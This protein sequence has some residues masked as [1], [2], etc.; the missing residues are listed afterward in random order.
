MTDQRK[1]LLDE[2]LPGDDNPEL[3]IEAFGRDDLGQV[4]AER[5][6]YLDQLQRSL[7]D[8]A[9]FRKRV[10]QERARARA[11][12]TRDVLTQLLP[13][14]DDMQRALSSVP[15]D[16]S[17]KPWVEGMQLIDKKL[18][19]LLTREGVASIDALGVDFDPSEHEAVAIDPGSSGQKVVEVFQTGYRQG[20][21]LLRPAMV[22]VG[23]LPQA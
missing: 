13:L 12:A 10:D 19:M 1:S 4:T 6:S 14:V 22:R 2:A 23:D 11:F 5:D 17:A 18:Q 9:N 3:E 8:F 20:G 21:D 15:A 7:A 16:Q